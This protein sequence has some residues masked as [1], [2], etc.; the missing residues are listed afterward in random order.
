ML[1]GA[2]RMADANGMLATLLATFIGSG[3]GTT[4]V[5]IL[6]K[7]R[8]DVQL[9]RQK[10]FLQRN[11]KIHERQVDA[12]IAIHSDLEHA[13]FYLQRVASA[14]RFKGEADDQT[15]LQRMGKELASAAEQFSKNQLLLTPV[16]AKR[17]NEFF[18]KT[19]D[20]GSSLQF[21]QEFAQYP[22][23]QGG[24]LRAELID[25]AREVAFKEIPEIL[26]A[27]RVE[28]KKII[29]A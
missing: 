22:I 6:F 2:E 11:S 25:K 8:F 5:G 9:E 12:L 4:L 16:L 24:M 15:Q 20:A 14:G 10:A 18:N 7:H 21:S 29:N 28:A 1:R 17:L 23:V 13:L 3:A 27:I 19:F 26:E